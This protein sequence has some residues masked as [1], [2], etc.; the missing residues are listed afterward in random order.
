GRVFNGAGTIALVPVISPFREDGERARRVVGPDRFF[1]I[2]LCTSLEVCESRDVKGLYG[3]ARAGEIAEFTGISSPYEPPADA[4]LIVD[5]AE[6]TIQECV[7]M[8]WEAIK[9]TIVR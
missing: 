7:E 2:Y 1:E 9:G 8:I 3:K 5:T 6:L 4:S